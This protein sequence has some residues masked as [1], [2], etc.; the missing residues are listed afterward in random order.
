M[1][2][3][4][5]NTA[6]AAVMPDSQ[7]GYLENACRIAAEYFER[8]ASDARKAIPAAEAAEAQEP[9]ACRIMTAQGL[10][11]SADMFDA[12]AARYRDMRELLE[13]HERDSEPLALVMVRRPNGEDVFGR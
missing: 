2:L 9:D 3:L 4:T 12:E 11:H 5:I 6:R 8:A 7:K 1:A 13:G 10:K